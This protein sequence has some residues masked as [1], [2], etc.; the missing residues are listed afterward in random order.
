VVIT[1]YSLVSSLLEKLWDVRDVDEGI[2]STVFHCTNIQPLTRRQRME[3]RLEIVLKG[4]VFLL[5]WSIPGTVAAVLNCL[6][7]FLPQ[8]VASEV[9]M[10]C[11]NVTSYITL[12]LPIPI[13]FHF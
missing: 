13:W 8:S 1:Q 11:Q 2:A 7:W 9:W 3:A 6:V 5:L 12:R 4:A 10:H